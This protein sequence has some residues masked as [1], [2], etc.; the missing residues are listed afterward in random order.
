[1]TLADKKIFPWKK[2]LYRIDFINLS[3]CLS[4]RG[5]LLRANII[6]FKNLAVPVAVNPN[7]SNVQHA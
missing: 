4:L 7:I 6:D 3:H 2:T 5:I 1:M